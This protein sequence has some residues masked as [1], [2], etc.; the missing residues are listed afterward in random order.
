MEKLADVL[1]PPELLFSRR[2]VLACVAAI[3]VMLVGLLAEQRVW[4]CDC[5]SWSPWISNVDS[6]HCS[7]HM[8]DAYSASH[9]LHGVLFYGLL[10][11][12][13]ARVGPGWRIWACIA[14]EAAWEVLENSQMVIDRYR[15]A[16]IALGYTG[17]SIA[18]SVCD[19][20]SCVVGYW[21][22]NRISWKWSVGFFVAVELI[23]LATIR[24]SLVL[25]VVMLV[26]PLEVVKQW[27]LRG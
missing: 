15:T 22:A 17:D 7:Q 27:Q 16:T 21:L 3:V 4:F 9:V 24:D 25:N 11:L 5:G 20:F 13:R 19:V 2:I 1:P 12:M 23:M 10:W 6:R 18:N 26:Y 14:L 8:F